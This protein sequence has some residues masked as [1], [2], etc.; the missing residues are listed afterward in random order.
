MLGARRMGLAAEGED[1]VA[2]CAGSLLMLQGLLISAAVWDA[3]SL[4]MAGSRA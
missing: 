3:G 1:V 2:P 4:G